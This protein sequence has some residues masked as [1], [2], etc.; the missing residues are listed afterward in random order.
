MP[1]RS[2]IEEESLSPRR[3][4]RWFRIGRRP[5][6]HDHEQPKSRHHSPPEGTRGFVFRP[7]ES[8]GRATTHLIHNVCT[9]GDGISL[10]LRQYTQRPNKMRCKSRNAVYSLLLWQ[11]QPL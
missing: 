10:E 2:L 3:L 4:R 8:T 6:R 5:R 9:S 11:V 7:K 1:G